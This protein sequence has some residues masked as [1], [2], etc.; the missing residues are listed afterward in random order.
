MST[1]FGLVFGT[2]FMF[3]ILKL[4]SLCTCYPF[5]E[6]FNLKGNRLKSAFKDWVERVVKCHKNIW[7]LHLHVKSGERSTYERNSRCFDVNVLLESSWEVTCLEVS[8][9][10]WC[11]ILLNK[12]VWLLV[13]LCL[14]SLLANIQ[15]K[16]SLWQSPWVRIHLKSQHT[17]KQLRSRSM[18]LEN[19]EV[20]RVS[21][22]LY[23]S[24]FY[25]LLNS[26]CTSSTK[27][28]AQKR[29][30]SMNLLPNFMLFF[31]TRLSFLFWI[32]VVDTHWLHTHSTRAYTLLLNFLTKTMFHNRQAK[33]R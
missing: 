26:L 19:L 28:F 21:Y 11:L 32:S 23:P 27:S 2:A 5:A 24:S 10:I 30:I 13:V 14:L 8:F 7:F 29:Q 31:F 12:V 17:P 15:E 1:I 6:T 3:E 22:S 33:K 4:F 25:C 20:R 16:V 9:D 18:V